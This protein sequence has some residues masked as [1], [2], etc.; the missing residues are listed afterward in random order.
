MSSNQSKTK[1]YLEI[2]HQI[3]EMITEDQ[4]L[5]GDKLPSE[6]ELSERLNVGR[7]SVREAFR[8]LEL[9]GLI[10]TRRGEGTYL[11]D[12]TNHQ[13]VE[14][15]STFILQDSQ[16]RQ[17]VLETKAL[18]EKDV[19]RLVS[20]EQYV[21]KLHVLKEQL[22][23]EEINTEDR[24]Y[25]QLIAITENRLLLKIW[26]IINE[27]SS[28]LISNKGNFIH[29]DKYLLLLDSIIKRNSEHAIEIYDT[30]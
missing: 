23:S 28:Q 15:L 17:D 1:L 22:E 2:V 25:H 18:I 10:E 3:R 30:M 14:L 7:S 8:A 20:K 27:Y 5:P 13:L 16:V 6:R 9:L 4:L 24:F 26:Q 12:F 19:I 29:R 21:Q 11:R